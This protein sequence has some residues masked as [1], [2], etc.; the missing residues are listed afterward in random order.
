MSRRSEHG[1]GEVQITIAKCGKMLNPMRVESYALH[2]VLKLLTLTDVA[3]YCTKCV[4]SPL[5]IPVS[6]LK[7]TPLL[8]EFKLG[9][10]VDQA[11]EGTL[12]SI[13]HCEHPPFF[14]SVF[15]IC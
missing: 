2:H 11:H 4:F 13:F 10:H 1:G 3:C 15:L 12:V 5:H 14:L 7:M 8:L 6:Q 9:C